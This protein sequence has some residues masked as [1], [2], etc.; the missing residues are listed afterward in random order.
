MHRLSLAAVTAIA[1]CS[2]TQVVAADGVVLP[3]D[4]A[5]KLVSQCS[6]P[7]PGPVDSYWAPS[8]GDIDALEAAFPAFFR[9]KA[10]DWRGFLGM[11]NIRDSDADKLLSQYV[12]QYAGFV[13][14]GRKVIYVNAVTGWGISDNPNQWRTKAVRVCDGGS[15]T[16]GVEYD[17]TSKTFDHFAFNGEI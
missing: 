11:P 2:Y 4:E 8:K 5:A 1:V 6:R 3:N 12:R 15:I 9:K 13:I 7:S 17:P 16:F 14:G 10:Y